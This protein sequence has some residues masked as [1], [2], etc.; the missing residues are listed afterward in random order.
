MLT[1]CPLGNNFRSIIFKLIIQ[2][3]ILGI[4]FWIGLRWIPKYCSYE[5]SELVQLML[6]DSTKP[7]PELTLTQ[8]Y[9]IVWFNLATVN[10]E[11]ALQKYNYCC[12][13]GVITVNSLHKEGKTLMLEFLWHGPQNHVWLHS[14]LETT[15][16]LRP[17]W[18]GGLFMQGIISFHSS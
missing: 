7:L 12:W 16:H 14:L 5:K 10:S 6:P 1:H 17:P 2:N 13:V 18:W 11:L 8:I 15:L 4:R 3:S 9:V